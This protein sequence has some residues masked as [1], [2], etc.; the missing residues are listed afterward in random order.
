MNYED[1]TYVHT[2]SATT[3]TTL[4][5]SHTLVVDILTHAPDVKQL[6]DV[7]STLSVGESTSPPVSEKRVQDEEQ[8]S[9]Q[10]EGSPKQTWV[11]KGDAYGE[12]THFIKML[13]IFFS[14]LLAL[15][16]RLPLLFQFQIY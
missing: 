1:T 14:R 7:T 9:P 6:I 12:I 2:L 11:A 13:D 16:R 15:M 10:T 5:L 3:I 4:I 8:Q